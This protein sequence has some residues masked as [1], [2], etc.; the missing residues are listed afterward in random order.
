MSTNPTFPPLLAVVL[1]IAVLAGSGCGTGDTHG[2]NVS[3]V[4]RSDVPMRSG[5]QLVAYRLRNP[6]WPMK[7]ICGTTSMNIIVE[8]SLTD[9]ELIDLALDLHARYPKTYFEILD[10]ELRI[11]DFDR[12][13]DLVGAARQLGEPRMKALIA[14]MKPW[15]KKHYLATIAVIAE[16]GGV[17]RWQ[18]IGSDAHPTKADERICYLD[19]KTIARSECIAAASGG[20]D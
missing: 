19:A 14:S 7:A 6:Q 17:F 10:S 16:E 4:V 13:A 12:L 18:L 2:I 1:C 11:K 15:E 20:A 3:P 8:R 9:Q 5:S